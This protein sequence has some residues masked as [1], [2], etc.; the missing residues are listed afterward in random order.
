M[1]EHVNFYENL[2]EAEMRLVHTVVLYDGEPYYV[3]AITDH[4]KD[5]IF[6]VYLDPL[7]S[8]GGKGLTH[9]RH[10][11]PYE[12]H[13]ETLDG[14]TRGDKMD[15][16]MEKT[17]D[18]TIIRKM[19][20]SPLFD[21]FRPF[22]L[23]MCNKGGNTYFVER[24]PTRHTQQGLTGNMFDTTIIDLG[25]DR[26][27][28]KSGG[29]S[30]FDAAFYDTIKGNYPSVYECIENLH[31]PKCGTGSAAFHRNFAVIRG[32]V[33][34]LFLVYKQDVIGYLPNGDLSLVKLEP[35]SAHL[36]ESVADLQCFANI[37]V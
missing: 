12:W 35:N 4:K 11:V 14:P 1:K 13:Q 15:E 36:K 23:G 31:D 20:N 17:K 6:R 10:S 29:V 5:G 37:T 24:Q 27:P 25:K 9:I 28:Y 30:L 18:S 21:R 19:M 22:P 34:L 8:E 26:N 33:G 7:G 3:L 2:K 32:P 16:F